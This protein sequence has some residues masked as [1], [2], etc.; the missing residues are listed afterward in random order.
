MRTPSERE[1]RAVKMCSPKR[2]AIWIPNATGLGLDLASGS[3]P[4]PARCAPRDVDL[5]E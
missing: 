1:T 5:S 3:T 2:A 4:Q